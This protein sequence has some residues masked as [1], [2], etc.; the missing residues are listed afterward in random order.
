MPLGNGAGSATPPASA[1]PR[2]D[3]RLEDEH[4]CHSSAPRAVASPD[5]HVSREVRL[6]LISTEPSRA[7]AAAML[8]S[9]GL[10][11]LNANSSAKTNES[12]VETGYVRHTDAIRRAAPPACPRS[13]QWPRKEKLDAGF[14]TPHKYLG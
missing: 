9:S 4:S 5:V 12:P 14:F 10:R 6:R 7:A 1:E 2:P 13:G 11:T 3:V 8:P